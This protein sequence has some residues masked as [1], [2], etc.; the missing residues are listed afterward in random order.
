ML[1][2]PVRSARRL[3]AHP[4]SSLISI[5]P[6][7]SSARS[8][9]AQ[10]ESNAVPSFLP[11]VD[12]DYLPPHAISHQQ[13]SPVIHEVTV[14]DFRRLLRNYN[15]EVERN[16]GFTIDSARILVQIWGAYTRLSSFRQSVLKELSRAEVSA[17]FSAARCAA[18]SPS[19]KVSNT[20][21]VIADLK[22]SGSSIPSHD[23]V[24][25][26]LRAS[27]DIKDGYDVSAAIVKS[28]IAAGYKPDQETYNLLL[29][30]HCRQYGPQIGE[31]WV[32]EHEIRY[33]NGAKE[34]CPGGFLRNIKTCNFILAAFVARNDLDGALRFIDSMKLY[35]LIPNAQ[36]WTLMVRGYMRRRNI[37]SARKCF[38]AIRIGGYKPS[39]SVYESL[40][41]GYLNFKIEKRP[42]EIGKGIAISSK[43]RQ[44][45]DFGLS[46]AS[47][48]FD[49]M[50]ESG[51]EP[52][53]GL[54][55]VLMQAHLRLGKHE[56]VERLFDGMS[57][58]NVSPD[59]FCYSVYLQSVMSTGNLS[60]AEALLDDMKASRVPRDAVLCTILLDGYG[61]SGDLEKAVEIYRDMEASGIKPTEVTICA[62]LN[63][64]CINR[65]MAGA[66]SVIESMPRLGFRRGLVAYNTI[67]HGY[68]LA[69]DLESADRM[70]EEMIR[71]AVIPAVTTYNTLIASHV[72]A[73]DFEG[74]MAW[75][76]RLLSSGNEPS[77]VTF[78][79]LI[80]SN[81]KRL[82]MIGA[83]DAYTELLRR[84]YQP[85]D[86]T[87]S[88]LISG[89]GT[90]GDLR[91]AR[92]I[93]DSAKE[94]VLNREAHVYGS[95]ETGI[96]RH[97]PIMPHNIVIKCFAKAGNLDAMVQEYEVAMAPPNSAASGEVIE[98]KVQPDVRTFDILVRAFAS[99]GDV[100]GAKRWMDEAY[101][102][103]VQ[104]DARLCNAL[105]S[106]FVKVGDAEGA[107]EAYGRM[108]K[109]GIRPDMFTYTL[110]LRAHQKAGMAK[111]DTGNVRESVDGFEEPQEV[112][113]VVAEKEGEASVAY[114]FVLPVKDDNTLSRRVQG[115]KEGMDAE[116]VLPDADA[117]RRAFTVTLPANSAVPKNFFAPFSSSAEVRAEGSSS[118]S[119]A[120]QLVNSILHGS[121]SDAGGEAEV[122]TTHSKLLARG[123]SE[124]YSR[125]HENPDF[126]VRLYG[127][128]KTEIGPLDQ[129]LHIW[130][131]NKYQGY[132]ETT[133][134]LSK[135][136]PYQKFLK[137]LRPMLRSRESQIMLE[138][139]FWEGSSPSFTDGIYEL[140]TYCLKPGRMLEWEHEWKK[141]LEARRK[142]VQ[143]VGAWFSQ[144][145]DLNYVHH[146]WAYE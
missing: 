60:R 119:K 43:G 84:G 38:E 18:R 127:S 14:A 23:Q 88:P 74:A 79:I 85:D 64:Y 35:H 144:L 138:F 136:A 29:D 105:I 24:L 2:S 141:G 44:A 63:A 15:T 73:G 21:K 122:G 55:H 86:A 111:S 33:I 71:H 126:K 104:P 145:G 92:K 16:F 142:F 66:R 95:H 125:I 27:R 36:S 109:E 121:P 62:L 6:R 98:E 70:Y 28:H 108:V 107:R 80:H 53:V 46:E 112:D 82:N 118:A 56:E 89:Y 41:Y 31:A 106:A 77:R 135:D 54:Y 101:K 102:R 34:G 32:R 51:Y 134:L 11:A 90:Q 137:E 13:Y 87:F 69:G 113:E 130:E 83:L 91:S 75:Y 131:Y 146:L 72:R 68:G 9:H 37:V 57:E 81:A 65:D 97:N 103:G 61:K 100:E 49:E 114:P 52:G 26:E 30:L 96:V 39:R 143:P 93:L 94:A 117:R 78:N 48:L 129:G 139:A 8:L 5:F 115:M 22:A 47:T 3:Q 12:P 99:F 42:T 123:N 19:A 133:L 7:F 67:I 76:D 40:I 120:K 140:R 17:V 59:L 50:L 124:Q 116:A 110:L 58:S 20:R 128:W 1:H 10:N 45:S 132:D 4:P 25:A